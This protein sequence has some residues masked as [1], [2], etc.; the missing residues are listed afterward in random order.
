V[1]FSSV[2]NQNLATLCAYFCRF[3]T[4]WLTDRQ[5]RQIRWIFDGKDSA[6]SFFKN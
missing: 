5:T 4:A 1:A 6:T 2:V 3:V